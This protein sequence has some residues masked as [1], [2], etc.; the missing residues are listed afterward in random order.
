MLTCGNLQEDVEKCG[1][2]TWTFASKA[3]SLELV[4]LG[5]VNPNQK[6]RISLSESCSL[7][8]PEVRGEDVGHYYCQQFGSGVKLE[9]DAHVYLSVVTREYTGSF[10]IRPFEISYCCI[11]LFL[12]CLS[13]LTGLS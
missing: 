2:T 1:S 3:G 7:V 11:F 8:I 10:Q 9:P 5:T 13:V 6:S 12:R 4:T